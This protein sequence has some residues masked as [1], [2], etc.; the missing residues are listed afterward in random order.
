MQLTSISFIESKGTPQEWILDALVL[1]PKN[2]IVGKNTSG[3]SRSLNVISGL[4]KQLMGVPSRAFGG[5]YDAVF[6]HGGKTYNYKVSYLDDEVLTEKLT[7]DGKI[8]LDR[9]NGGE[10]TMVEEDDEGKCRRFHAPTTQLAAVVRR[11]KLQHSYLEPLYEWAAAVR[12][13]LF[14]SSFG[15]ENISMIVPGGP[16][17]FDE[18]DPNAVVPIFRKAFRQYGKA[19]T[20]AVISDLKKI[21][22]DVTNVDTGAPISMRIQGLPGEV[23]SLNVK[24][25]DLAGNTDQTSMSQGMYRVLSLLIHLNYCQL[26]NAASCILIDDIGE[27]LDFDRS[28][29]LIDLIREKSTASAIQ[30]ILTTNDRFVMNRVPLEEWSVIQRRG[31]HVKFKNHH[32]SREIFEEFKFTGLSN[33]S[34]LELDVVNQD[35]HT[36]QQ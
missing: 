12:V 34:F 20:D 19:F 1:G 11:D 5:E 28:C 24:E 15:K 27:G 16:I 9:G 2:L 3:K 32:N 36:I 33:F 30:L 18:R 6:D 13:F 14:G 23:V 22:Y 17:P 21:D 31:N 8:Y 35:S 26:A 7:I 10:G 4:A 29:Q 25:A